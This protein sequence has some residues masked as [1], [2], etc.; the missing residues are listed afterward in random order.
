MENLYAILGID[1]LGFEAGDGDI[2][3]AYRNLALLYHPDKLGENITATDKE[4]WLKVQNAYEILIDST[5]RRKFDSS[6]PFNENIPSE[7]FDNINDNNYY[8]IFG[9]VFTRNA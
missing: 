2:K 9:P 1:H 8:D 7:A 3:A 4:V 5:R 6:L